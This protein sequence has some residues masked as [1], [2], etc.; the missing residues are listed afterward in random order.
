MYYILKLKPSDPVLH[1]RNVFIMQRWRLRQGWAKFRI[2]EM[3]HFKFL[4]WNLN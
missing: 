2:E 3:A 4:S 1:L